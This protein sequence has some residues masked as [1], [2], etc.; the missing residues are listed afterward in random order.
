MPT[1]PSQFQSV[2]NKGTTAMHA[3]TDKRAA[4][5]TCRKLALAVLLLASLPPRPVLSAGPSAQPQEYCFT[6]EIDDGRPRTICISLADYD[7]DVCGAIERYAVLWDLP[8][9]Y[10]ARLIWQE[11]HFN[12]N[13]VS[14]AGAEGISQFIP[15]TAQL[16]GVGNVYDPSEALARSARYLRFLTDEFGSLGLAAAAYNG[17][18]GAVTR[19][20]AGTGFLALE[21][22]D[23]VQIIT[24]HS[25]EE[26][27]AGGVKPGDFALQPNMA[28]QRACLDL[29]QNSKVNNFTPPSAPLKP[30][31]VQL[32][33]N[34]SAAVARRSFARAQSR[35]NILSVEQ[36][37]MVAARNLHFGRRLR[38]AAMIGRDTRAAAEKLCSQLQAAG[39]ACS[40][41]R[42][43]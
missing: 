22:L 39:G 29:V 24:G 10:F 40:V 17:G 13:A 11:S 31:G 30:W 38:Y 26:W 34:F 21:T 41:V 33:E 32:A 5:A 4:S 14:G 3:A 6:R 36:P 12:P 43:R 8:P 19:Y 2:K 28:F 9:G 23:Y 15:S 25:I 37:M 20:I 1:W 16:Q 42:N 18:E 35:F 7:A 27:I